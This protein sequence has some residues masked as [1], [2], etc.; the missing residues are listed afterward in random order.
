MIV[1]CIFLDIPDMRKARSN[2]HEDGAVDREN[3]NPVVKMQRL[4]SHENYLQCHRLN[5]TF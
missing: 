1:I 5:V 3:K 2:F 4:Q